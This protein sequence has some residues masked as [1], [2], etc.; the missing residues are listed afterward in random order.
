MVM[1]LL[2]KIL[3][4]YVYNECMKFD[5]HPSEVKPYDKIKDLI[6]CGMYECYGFY[7]N[8]EMLGYAF[9]L[10]DREHKVIYLD[11]LAV[12]GHCRR[13]GHGNTILSVMRE[14]FGG[15][16]E[17][18]IAEVEDPDYAENASDLYARQGRINYYLNNA[19]KISGV[20]SRVG[21]DCYKIIYMDMNGEPDDQAI[22]EYMKHIYQVVFDKD[23]Y[24]NNVEV[25][26]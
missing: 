19:L 10:N 6:D 15:E 8:E 11:Y 1:E 23:Y 7:E 21:Q 13:K 12:L 26:K 24:E 25:E 16:Y 2:P 20:R 4:D 22:M 18:L 14:C 5:F 9:L 17:Y 3:I